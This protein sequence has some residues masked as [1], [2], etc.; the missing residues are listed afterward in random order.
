MTWVLYALGSAITFSLV[1][2]LDKVLLQK[3]I[4]SSRVFIILV[5]FV[6]LLLALIVLPLASFTGYGAD[7]AA[8]AIGSGLVT[9]AYLILLFWAISLQDVSRVVP[10]ASTYPIFIAVI[11][12]FFLGE[13][14][15]VLAWTGIC[16]TVAG[17]GLM[18]FGP[19]ARASD[20]GKGQTM[21][22]A[23]LVTA[24]LLFGL[25]QI[26]SKVV[27]DDMDVWTLL[28]WRM[29]GAAGSLHRPPGQDAGCPRYYEG[30]PKP[31][32]RRTAAADRGRAGPRRD[33]VHARSDLQ[34]PGVTGFHG[35]GHQAAV[36]VRTR[37]SAEHGS[38][39]RPERA[40]GGQDHR[41]EG[42]GHRDDG[43]GCG[44]GY[45]GVKAI[46]T[47][48][49]PCPAVSDLAIRCSSRGLSTGCTWSASVLRIMTDANRALSM[50]AWY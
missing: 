46:H 17:V 38:V 45:S 36:R 44:G 20:M 18:S 12:Q 43:G 49:L 14:L 25:T 22:F 47:H 6:Q 50:F 7:D 27:A 11:A 23:L 31:L 4:P 33:G 35:D 41:D 21:V 40:V 24:S 2:T 28:M 10:V 32:S 39:E 3:Y 29:L 34:R 42:A 15:G 13:E 37:D 30:A 48:F 26:M 9:G 16:V 19:T 1:S 5:G 8:I